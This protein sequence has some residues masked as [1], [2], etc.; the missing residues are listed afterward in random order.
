MNQ[1][2]VYR[3]HLRAPFQFS[4][5]QKNSLGMFV[6]L[7]CCLVFAIQGSIYILTNLGFQPIAQV[8]LPFVSYGGSSLFINFIVLGII[9]SVFRNSNIQK[10]VPYK[11]MIAINIEK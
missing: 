10:E 2:Y 11:K 3:R 1:T 4:C 7:G 9:L 5:H 8:N 6:G